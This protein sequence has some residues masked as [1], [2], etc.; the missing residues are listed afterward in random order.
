MSTDEAA[1]DCELTEGIVGVEHGIHEGRG[2]GDFVKMHGCVIEVSRYWATSLWHHPS[3]KLGIDALTGSPLLSSLRP[4]YMGDRRAT[5][6]DTSAPF[7]DT[8]GVQLH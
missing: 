5:V 8:V 6:H 1:C 7:I 4:S 3:F 2:V